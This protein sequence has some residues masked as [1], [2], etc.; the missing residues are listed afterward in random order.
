[1]TEH[2]LIHFAIFLVS[3]KFVNS[4]EAASQMHTNV[5]NESACEST[6]HKLHSYILILFY[7]SALSSE[8]EHLFD[9]SVLTF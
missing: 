2:N 1:M 6:L 7:F 4:V 9:K 5:L 3:R 8:S